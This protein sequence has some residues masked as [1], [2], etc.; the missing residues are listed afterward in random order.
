[1]RNN[2]LLI[3]NLLF[4]SSFTQNRIVAIVG[5][6]PIFESDII[7]KSKIE[8]IDYSTSLN[9]LIE[10]RLLLYWA[11][12]ENI[13]VKEEEIK[14]EIEK[15]KKNFSKRED[16]Y[17]YLRNI[18]MNIFQFEE[19]VAN[20]IKLKK[21]IK[22]KIIK[23]IQITLVEISEEVKKIEL[24]YCEYE[25][26][27]KWFDTKENCENFIE[28]FNVDDLKKMEY[29]KLKSSE[30]VEDIL[31]VI[32]HMEKEKLS[33][34]LQIKEKWMVIYLKEKIP[35]E[36]EKYKKYKEAKDRIFK[37]KF[38]LLYN[39]YIKKLKNLTQIKIF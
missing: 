35:L 17:N 7:K 5:N 18:G 2:L 1:M 10:E 28:R 25:F 21:L 27:F 29:V 4:I 23:E 37:I 3:F 31:N 13:E 12:K 8:N 26:Y 36:I 32:E 20:G 14:S 16:F 33:E 22:E 39:E 38:A 19:E 34:P 11:E 30:I 9:L 6:K 24:K 15:I